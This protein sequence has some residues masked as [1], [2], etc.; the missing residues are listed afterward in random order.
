MSLWVR[1]NIMTE[2]S[3]CFQKCDRTQDE[4]AC[5]MICLK[6]CNFHY[7]LIYTQQQELTQ[8]VGSHGSLSLPFVIKA[9]SN[10]T[11]S[12][13]NK[14]MPALIVMV[15]FKLLLSEIALQSYRYVLR[16]Y[17]LWCWGLITF[18]WKDYSF[19]KNWIH[20]ENWYNVIT[21]PSGTWHLRYA[22]GVF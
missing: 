14:V 3:H 21:L 10:T 9:I 13:P 16:L 8:L 15:P 18:L 7:I 22:F 4:D 12:N 5:T 19:C 20:L 17:L 6:F 2:S 1:A 11:R